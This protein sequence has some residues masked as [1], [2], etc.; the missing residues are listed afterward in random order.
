[1]LLAIAKKVVSKNQKSIRQNTGHEGGGEK[2]GGG[3]ALNDNFSCVTRNGRVGKKGKVKGKRFDLRGLDPLDLFA[4]ATRPWSNG[5]KIQKNAK[6]SAGG[7]G[8]Y[9]SAFLV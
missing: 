6:Q 8:T 2:S 1:M 5:P 3:E 4:V 9:L 7:Q